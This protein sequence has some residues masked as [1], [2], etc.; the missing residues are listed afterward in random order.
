MTLSPH[1]AAILN[2][3]PNHLD[4]HGTMEAYTAAK[5]ASWPSSAAGCGR[6]GARGPGRL[7]SAPRR[8]SGQA[9]LLRVGPRPRAA[10][11]PVAEGHD[12]LEL[13]GTRYPA[14]APET[15]SACAATTTSLNVL[16]ACAIALRPASRPG[17]QAGVQASRACPT[18]WSLCA[19]GTAPPGTTIRSSPPP[20]GRWLPFA[21]FQEPLVLLLGGRDKD[22][23]WSDLAALVSPAGR[24]RGPVRRGRR[25]DQRCHGHRPRR[26]PLHPRT[27]RGSG[28]R[29]RGGRGW[30]RPALRGPLSPG[31]TSFDQFRD[32]ENEER[33]SENGYRHF[34][35][36]SVLS[37]R[38]IYAPAGHTWWQLDIPL[39][40][41]A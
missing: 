40:L 24:P 10:R 20:S 32:F 26:G 6:P 25:E 5:S 3:T 22:L 29:R 16:A 18:A 11:G 8:C 4:R 37:P 19:S 15:S 36:K 7:G 28:G 39:V 38:S 21:R 30:A 27:L 1:V 2:V 33:L 14:I 17:H 23:P 9:A 13:Q 34:R 31:G 12:L 41:A 35:H